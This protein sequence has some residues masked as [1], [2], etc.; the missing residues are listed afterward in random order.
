MNTSQ[1]PSSLVIGIIVLVI[2]IILAVM[3]GGK[4]KKDQTQNGTES[5]KVGLVLPLTGPTADFG[6]IFKDGIE[7]AMKDRTD[8]KLIYE[9]SKS[10]PAGALSAFQKTTSVDNVDLVIS[11][12]SKTSIPLVSVAKEQKVPL[13]FSLVAAKTATSPDNDYAYRIFWTSDVTGKLFADRMIAQKVKSVGIIYEKNEAVQQNMDVILPALKKAGIAVVSENFNDKDIDFRTQLQKIKQA[14]PEVFAV[15]S[16]PAG[17]W[18]NI[19]TQA[20]EIGL[21]LPTYDVLGVLLNTGTPEA[22][23]KLAENVYTFTTPFNLGLYKPE[24]KQEIVAQFG[25]PQGFTSF[26]FD[27]A[28]LLKQMADA[29][30][31]G[32]EGVVDY[33]KA[34]KTFDGI[35]SK[36]TVDSAH[37]F[38]PEIIQ[39]QY[40]DGKIVKSAK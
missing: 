38:L 6:E 18:K 31:Q 8:I 25:E 12:L 3:F 35:T 39:A 7:N 28:S 26:A 22:L 23:G 29:K 16:V 24:S 10:D 21:N 20:N 15:L 2:I 34:T 1:K 13:L 30:V 27:T 36:Y 4:G 17:N 33:L 32:R 14:K 5:L 9:D 19:M 37:N 40:V 11:V